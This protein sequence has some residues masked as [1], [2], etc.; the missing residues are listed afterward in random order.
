MT[1]RRQFLTTSAVAVATAPHAF[2]AGNDVIK[3]GLI[4]CGERGTGAAVNALSADKNVKLVAMADAFQDR[5]DGSFN[6]LLA[7]KAVADRVD[8]KP[9]AKFVGFDAYKSV[10]ERCDVV[11]LTTPPQFRPL[12]LKAAIDAGKHVFAEK[13]CAVDAPGVRSVLES[14][15]KAKTKG[16]SVV[17][18]LCL[19]YDNGFRETVKRI[20][21]GAI[22]EVVTV[23]ANDYRGGRWTK[24]R[25]KEW[26]DMTYQMRNWYNFTWLSGD[27][28]VEQH[29]HFLDVAAWV[30]KDQYPVRAMG[31][32]GRGIYTGP[33]T[34][35]IFD[36]FSVV[37]EYEN[38]A[39]LVSNTRQQP[40][41]KS[42]MSAQAFGTKGRAALSEKD[43]GLNIKAEQNWTFDGP[44]NAMY[45]VEHE[46]LFASIRSGKPVN[47]GEYMANSTLLAIMGR[48][49]AYTGQQITW[50]MA[51][52]SKED[53]SPPKWDW[54]APLPEPAI[55]IPGVTKFV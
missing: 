36:H 3:I 39:R 18:G 31:M 37:Y 52:E 43:G 53:L 1:T 25:Q 17:S 27:F 32:G 11:L 35:N 42:D 55:S 44:G 41:T 19:R 14:C 40:R 45:Q 28:N 47:N 8:V 50:K 46:E 6:N 9:D 24:I 12:H 15:A 51:L 29:V 49:A 10:I 48:M 54:D 21:G 2:A 16:L 26:S 22:G 20:H 38:G 33:D 34:G 23:F 13:P 30:M 7:K 5:L 4:G